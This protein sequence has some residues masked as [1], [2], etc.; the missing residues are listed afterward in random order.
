M[1]DKLFEYYESLGIIDP[2][3]TVIKED[4]NGTT[5]LNFEISNERVTYFSGVKLKT[6]KELRENRFL[7]RAFLKGGIFIKKD[8][9]K[10]AE[11]LRAYSLFPFNRYYFQKTG[12]GYYLILEYDGFLTLPIFLINFDNSGFS[13]IFAYEGSS[14]RLYPFNI[15]LRINQRGRYTQSFDFG[16]KFPISI[17]RRMFV[18]VEIFKDSILQE[19]IVLGK[20]FGRIQI[21]TNFGFDSKELKSMGFSG[22]VKDTAFVFGSNV[23]YEENF[24][25]I[26]FFSS[27][28]Y[29]CVITPGIN[30]IYSSF[31]LSAPFF[32]G[33]NIVERNKIFS[34][35]YLEYKNFII[36]RT[37]QIPGKTAIGMLK[38]IANKTIYLGISKRD[39]ISSTRGLTLILFSFQN[40]PILDFLNFFN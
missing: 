36:S 1:V 39:D 20:H 21:S 17:E 29:P 7:K 6:G 4:S 8:Y 35:S 40:S 15:R 2:Q 12:E 24:Y 19:K 13:S 22:L 31:N 16:I 33:V 10:K 5:K 37:M 3:I 27:F 30:I 28:K 32:S 34:E 23:Q 25:K 18:G 9:E 38:K 14:Y 11:F 26:F